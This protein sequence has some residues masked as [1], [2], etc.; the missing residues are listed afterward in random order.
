MINHHFSTNFEPN[1]D[2]PKLT[3][4]LENSSSDIGL[5]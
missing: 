1:L 4:S 5:R 2:E 3:G